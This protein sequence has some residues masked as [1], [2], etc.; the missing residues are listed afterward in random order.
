MSGNDVL[1]ALRTAKVKTPILVLSGYADVGYE[2]KAFDLGADDYMV[3]PLHKD[4]LISRVAAV[5]RR[6][7]GISS[8]VI[9]V[10]DLVIDLSNKTA[11]VAGRSVHLTGQ[12]YRMLELL[13][14]RKGA[15]ITKEMFLNHLYGGRDEPEIKIIDVFICKLRK[16]LADASGGRNYVETL[17]GR[18]YALKDPEVCAPVQ[19]VKPPGITRAMIAAGRAEANAQ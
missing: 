7:R 18:G 12:E 13:A 16:K 3:T 5:I 11:S 1:R 10:G 4:V 19:H 9:T 6:S 14:L 17:W 15:T 2:V 8:P